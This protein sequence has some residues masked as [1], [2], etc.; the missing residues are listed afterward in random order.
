MLSHPG[1]LQGVGVENCR[2]PSV[3]MVA[4]GSAGRG[5]EGAAGMVGVTGNVK[6]G[7]LFPSG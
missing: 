6:V 1:I 2:P 5:G 3:P 4:E 7:P